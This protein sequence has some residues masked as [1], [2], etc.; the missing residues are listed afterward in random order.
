MK[1]EEYEKMVCALVKPGAVMKTEWTNEEKGIFKELSIC[2]SV[3][4]EFWNEVMI[5]FPPFSIDTDYELNHMALGLCGEIGELIDAYKKSTVYR[6]PLDNENITEEFGDIFFYT[7]SISYIIRSSDR[8]S[9]LRPSMS[10]LFMVINKLIKVCGIDI[11]ECRKKNHEKLSVRYKGLK[12]SDESAKE[13]AD[14]N[15]VELS[16]IL[17]DIIGKEEVLVVNFYPDVPKV[18]FVGQD[19]PAAL[20]TSKAGLTYDQELL[21]QMCKSKIEKEGKQ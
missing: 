17:N 19:I 11:V 21:I 13:R 20:Y 1:Y 9:E 15:F 18:C 5:M 6:K 12:Y 8:Y 14:K 10:E 7:C 16:F 2:N 3:A 4:A